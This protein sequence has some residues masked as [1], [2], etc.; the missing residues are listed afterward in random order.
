MATAEIFSTKAWFDFRS[1]DVAAEPQTSIPYLKT[2]TTELFLSSKDVEGTPVVARWS[3]SFTLDSNGQPTGG[4]VTRID[5]FDSKTG[6]ALWGYS[7]FSIDFQQMASTITSGSPNAVFTSLF[8]GDDRIAG[9]VRNDYLEGYGGNDTMI[10]GPGN[11]VIDGGAGWNTAVYAGNKANYTWQAG[12]DGTVI[13]TDGQ[14]GRDGSDILANVQLLQFK[15]GV[16]FVLTGDEARVAR[17]YGA[18][19]ARAPD[20]DGLHW[21]I[22]KGL[23]GGLSFLQLANNFEH[24]AEFIQRYGANQSDEDYVFQL[25]KNVLG[26]DPDPDGYKFQLD[27]VKAGLARDQLLLN[28]SDSAENKQHVLSDWMVLG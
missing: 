9:G 2:S 23:H 8:S 25:Y 28:F 10:G 21:Q 19:F 5:V 18:A 13:L 11:D 16:K 22:D 4:T 7:D 27:H 15:D 17:L 14:P 26:R 24:S 1:F 3:G 20:V 12:D 6:A